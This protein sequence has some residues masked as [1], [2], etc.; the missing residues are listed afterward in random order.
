MYR[1]NAASAI[2]KGFM[3]DCG[4]GTALQGSSGTR[5]GP[6]AYKHFF[7]DTI[8]T[9]PGSG[10]VRGV[11]RPRTGLTDYSLRRAALA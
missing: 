7:C 1:Q 6:D 10:P 3:P 9:T 2:R 8:L 11:A 5:T 4:L